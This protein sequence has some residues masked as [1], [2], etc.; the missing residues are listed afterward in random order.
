MTELIADEKA[1]TKGGVRTVNKHRQIGQG[2]IRRG[3]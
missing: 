1:T 2:I 3:V